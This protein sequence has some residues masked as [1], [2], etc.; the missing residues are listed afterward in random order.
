M[1]YLNDVL[2]TFWALNLSVALPSMELSGFI[3]KYLNLY[4]EDE[5]RSYSLDKQTNERNKERIN[6]WRI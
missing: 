6:E 2:T 1:D 3:K 5:R 4:T